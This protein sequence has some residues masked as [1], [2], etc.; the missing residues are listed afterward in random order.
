MQGLVLWSELNPCIV[1]L[2]IWAG[3][4]A[5]SKETV[6]NPVKPVQTAK[7][8]NSKMKNKVLIP[9]TFACAGHP[10]FSFV[11]I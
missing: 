4:N 3:W 2:E 1:A 10:R 9:P 8:N 7:A 6:T 5:F 11:L